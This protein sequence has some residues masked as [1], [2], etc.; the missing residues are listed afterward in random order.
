MTL[1]AQFNNDTW[2]VELTLS[3]WPEDVA[4]VERSVN[5]V[6]WQTVR[7]G[8]NLPVVDGSAT[9]S[10]WEYQEGVQN[11]YRVRSASGSGSG[12]ETANITP[13][14]G[15]KIILKSVRFPFLNR[16]I[17]VTDFTDPELDDRGG[18]FEVS[19]RSVPVSTPDQRASNMFTVE[20]MTDT[21]E[22]ARD[23][24][25][26][27]RANPHLFLHVPAG[28][29][30]PGGHVRVGSVTPRRPTRSAGTERRYWPLPCRLVAPPGPQVVGGTMTY[31][32]LL[33]LYGG[34]DNVLAANSEYADLLALMGSPDDLVVI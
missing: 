21:R 30:V 25:L 19:G 29:P 31:A 11:T 4:L 18:M 1:T 26:I 14:H 3:G 12:V 5:G 23:M 17:T 15:G 32:G 9:L 10:D 28:C 6:F 27:L 2:R 22:Q 20:L 24:Q 8:V 13:S 16:P 33:N 7:G 34:Y